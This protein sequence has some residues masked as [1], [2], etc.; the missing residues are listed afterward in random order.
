MD[1][2]VLRILPYVVLAAVL[3]RVY[4]LHQENRALGE[5]LANLNAAGRET[6]E[7]LYFWKEVSHSLMRNAENPLTYEEPTLVYAFDPNCSDCWDGLTLLDSYDCTRVDVVAVS[8][9]G[10]YEIPEYV[11]TNVSSGDWDRLPLVRSSAVLFKDGRI[12]VWRILTRSIDEI[13]SAACE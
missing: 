8:V 7:Q 5:E 6:D 10:G 2:R 1:D 9:S 12:R 11:I 13:R 3:F 4:D